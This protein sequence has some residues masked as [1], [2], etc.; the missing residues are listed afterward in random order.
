M[1]QD[2][3]C[4]ISVTFTPSILGTETGTLTVTDNA[5]GSP[6]SAALAGTG[7]VPVALSPASPSF[8]SQ[9]EYTTSAAKAITLTNN[10][11]SALA[12]SNITTSGDFAQTNTCGSSVAANGKCTISVTFTPSIIGA[13][14]GTLTVTDGAS[15]SPQ[16]ASLAGTGMVPAALSPSSRSFGNQ[17][18]NTTSAVKTITFSNNLDTALAISNITAS[19][20]FAQTNTCG[21]SVPANG[22]CS[23]SVTFTPTIIGADTGTLTVTD[24]ASNSPQTASL[25]GTGIEQAKVAPAS[26]GFGGETVGTSTAAKNVTLTNNLSATLPLSITFTGA[27]PGDFAETDTCAGSLAANSVCTISVTFTPTTTG[28][29]TA[30]LNV[31]DSANNSPQTVALTGTGR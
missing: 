27:N 14:T 6:Q 1:P 26:L 17:P 10:L 23:I 19:G 31:N 21:S 20:D 4:T 15:N 29:R 28:A 2:V 22:Q 11:D 25:T 7:V 3:R 24:G 9:A 5:T 16:T 12:I 13:D 18:E 30:S 8:G